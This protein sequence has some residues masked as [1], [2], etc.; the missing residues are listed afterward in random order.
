MDRQPVGLT[1]INIEL[2]HFVVRYSHRGIIN[3]ISLLEVDT[4]AK[5][6][7]ISIPIPYNKSDPDCTDFDKSEI[8]RV[9]NFL[10]NYK[11]NSAF[12]NN[13]VS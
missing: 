9:E 1:S 3:I 8:I 5:G 4:Y 11:V 12:L 7:F 13:H 10:G 2:I 6:L